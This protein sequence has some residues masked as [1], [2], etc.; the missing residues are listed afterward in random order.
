MEKKLATK[1]KLT[2]TL[3]L[4]LALTFSRSV[5]AETDYEREMMLATN[6]L[7]KYERSILGG[8]FDEWYTYLSPELQTYI[9]DKNVLEN[10]SN[11]NPLLTC[12]NLRLKTPQDYFTYVVRFERED[13]RYLFEGYML[14]RKRQTLTILAKQRGRLRRKTFVFIYS[15]I[16]NNWVLISVEDN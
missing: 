7:D 9:S 13:G 16:S 3:A 4:I 14:D 1:K 2:M 8:R 5:V 15:N 11:A 10:V 6:V 12:I